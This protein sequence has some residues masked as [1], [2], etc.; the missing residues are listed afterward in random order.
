M[1]HKD[2][3]GTAL[4]SGFEA[5]LATSRPDPGR[6]LESEGVSSEFGLS[7]ICASGYV[8]Q[9]ESNERFSTIQKQSLIL[10]SPCLARKSK[11]SSTQGVLLPPANLGSTRRLQASAPLRPRARTPQ[12][13]IGQGEDCRPELNSSCRSPLKMAANEAPWLLPTHRDLMFTCLA[14]TN[15]T[16]RRIQLGS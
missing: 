1:S 6:S 15:A 9:L 4:T 2:H 13:R 5:C 16:S 10:S 3:D 7:Q 8:W 11:R 14:P 12:R